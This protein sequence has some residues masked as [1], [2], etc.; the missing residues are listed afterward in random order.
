MS[1]Y[2]MREADEAN[3]A[4]EAPGQTTA[5][6]KARLWAV[7]GIVCGVLALILPIVFGP[8][9]I[10]LGIVARVK[11]AGTIST[12]AIVISVVLMVLSIVASV[13]ITSM[14]APGAAGGAAGGAGLILPVM[15]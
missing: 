11:G 5:A 6:P 10:V 13:V 3:E 9:G 1:D 8:A 4:N 15:L 12:A 7:A 2:R 14:F